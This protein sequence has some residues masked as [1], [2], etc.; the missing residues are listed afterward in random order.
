VVWISNHGGRHLDH[1]RPTLDVLREVAPVVAGKASIVVDGGFM[2]G[3]DFIKAITFGATAVA[4]GRM[5]AYALAA[6]G[7]AGVQRYLEI[8]EEE[9][10][11]TMAALGVTALVGLNPGYLERYGSAG[12]APRPFP[13]LPEH[14]VI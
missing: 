12:T 11:T 9:M 8:V 5:Q 7:A 1:A 13:G 2:R 4:V 10:Q 14:I 3:G 6:G